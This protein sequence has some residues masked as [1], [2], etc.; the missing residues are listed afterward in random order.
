MIKGSHHTSETRKKMSVSHIGLP[1]PWVSKR[2]KGNIPSEET[3]RKL[4][5]SHKGIPKPNVSKA[6][7]GHKVSLETRDKIRKSLIGHRNL[8][9]EGRQRKREL[10]KLWWSKKTQ[11]ERSF[12]ASRACAG[13]KGKSFPS[14]IEF[15]VRGFLIDLDIPFGGN[16]P[17]SP[18]IVD[19]LLPK[20]MIIIECDGEYWHS[21][22][23]KSER[24]KRKD[25]FLVGLGYQVIR[26]TD[27]E[28]NV[29]D[30]EEMKT[31]IEDA[32][33]V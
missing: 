4:S 11:D 29:M 6:L 9:E 32:K 12:Y 25:E 31:L 16:I 1:A 10:K 30:P 15:K 21:L 24:D 3:R 18:Y 20:H 33:T 23:D 14:S 19:L 28:I 27:K 13:N 17:F 7:M 5:E 22:P 8:T 26:I 2:M